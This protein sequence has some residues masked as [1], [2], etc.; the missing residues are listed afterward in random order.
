M[1]MPQAPLSTINLM[2]NKLLK[3]FVVDG[4]TEYF[5]KGYEKMK[6]ENTNYGWRVQ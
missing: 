3:A 4:I 6:E 1:K 2:V 5:S